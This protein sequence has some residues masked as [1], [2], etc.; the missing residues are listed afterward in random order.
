M[1]DIFTT[2]LGSTRLVESP[3]S[4]FT[5]SGEVLT[6]SVSSQSLAFILWNEAVWV[7]NGAEG[8][9]HEDL[10][11]YISEC[12]TRHGT[13]NPEG[14]DGFDGTYTELRPPRSM[15]SADSRAIRAFGEGGEWPPESWVAGRA[16]RDS[17]GVWYMSFWQDQGYVVSEARTGVE[18]VASYLKGP[19]MVELWHNFD[20]RKTGAAGAERA[21]REAPIAVPLPAYL[22]GKMKVSGDAEH[23]TLRPE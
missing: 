22:S 1:Q 20:R 5:P 10:T 8:Q 11:Y 18:V 17:K 3:D 7:G 2:L 19:V 16:V 13:T 4:I 6:S 23:R 21:S 15:D 12:L 9:M 14:R